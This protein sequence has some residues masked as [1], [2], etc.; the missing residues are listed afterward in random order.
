MESWML[1]PKK[2]SMGYTEYSCELVN[3]LEPIISSYKAN[4]KKVLEKKDLKDKEPSFRDAFGIFMITKMLQSIRSESSDLYNSIIVELNNFENAEQLSARA[5]ALSSQTGYRSVNSADGAKSSSKKDSSEQNRQIKPQ[6][7]GYRGGYHN[8]G[9]PS[10]GGGYYRSGNFSR[11]QPRRANF[12]PRGQGRGN[13]RGNSSG[14]PYVHNGHH[15]GGNGH[16]NSGNG[17]YNGGNRHYNGGNHNQQNGQ[18]TNTPRTY[19]VHAAFSESYAPLP[20]SEGENCDYQ[21]QHQGQYPSADYFPAGGQSDAQFQETEFDQGQSVHYTEQP[22][23]PA[24]FYQEQ[25][26][27]QPVYYSDHSQPPQEV[28]YDFNNGDN[29]TASLT[30]GNKKT[31]N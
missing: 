17:H 29:T 23:A 3:S 22:E 30:E 4:L 6:T 18:N 21:D 1:K 15:N 27:S 8:R 9:A 2:P 24:V 7:S 31:K 13:F 20:F 16:Y 10:R 14:R 25:A 19:G 26:E 5:E 11:G 12:Y 28:E